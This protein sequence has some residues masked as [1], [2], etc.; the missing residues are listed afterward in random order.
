ME[1]KPCLQDTQVED[2][3]LFEK[4]NAAVSNETER[5]QKLSFR[6][7]QPTSRNPTR[8]VAQVTTPIENRTPTE[9]KTPEKP[10]KVNLLSEVKELKVELA[11]IRE[12]KEVNALWDTAPQVR[13]ASKCRKEVNLLNEPVGDIIELL[14][15]DDL[16]LQVANGTKIEYDGWIEVELQMAGENGP[17]EP[18][19][20]PILI[21]SQDNQKHLIIGFKVIEEVI[22]RSS[23]PNAHE[24]LSQMVNNSLPSLKE[25]EARMLVNLIQSLDREPDTAVLRVGKQD[26]HI[27]ARGPAE[28]NCQVHFVPLEEDLPDVF[29]VKEEGAWS[30]GLEVKG[31]LHH[32]KPGSSSHIY[33]SEKIVSADGYTM[34]PADVAAIAALKET[35]PQTI[36]TQRKL[37]GFISY[38]RNYIQD[39]SRLA[40]PLCELLSAKDGSSQFH[41]ARRPQEHSKFKSSPPKGQLSSNY[42][43]AWNEKHQERLNSLI[44]RLTQPVVMAYPNF[45]LPF[46]LH[47]DASGEGLGAVLYQEQGSTLR[48]VGYGSRTLTPAERNYHLH[49]GKLEFLALKWAITDKFRD[50]LFYAPSFVVFTDNNPLTYVMSS[51]KLNA[52]GHR[53]VAEL[54]DYNFTIKYRPGKSNVDAEILSRMPLDI[55]EYVRECTEEVPKDVL[56]ATMVAVRDQG[57]GTTPWVT[58]ISADMTTPEPTLKDLH[59]KPF[60]PREIK[61]AQQSDN[62]I[63][64][65]TYYKTNDIKPGRGQLQNGPQGAANLMR[66]WKKLEVD[67]Q[68]ILRRRTASRIQLVLPHAF[69][70]LALNELHN[71]MGHLGVER[72][73]ELARSRFYWPHM[74]RDIEYFV[75]QQCRC[76]KQKKPNTLTKAPMHHLTTSAPFEVISIDFQHLDKSKGGYEYVLLI[77]DNFTK[78]AQAY[79]TR[80]KTARMAAEKIYNEF[81]PRFGFP[82]RLHH[83]QGGE[84][85]NKLFHNLERFSGVSSS[86]TTPYHPQGNGQVECMNCTLLSMLR[87]LPEEKKANCKD[88][89]NKLIHAYNCTRHETAG[90]SPIYLMFGRSPRLPIDLLFGLHDSLHHGDY[91]EYVKT[92]QASMKQAYAIASRNTTKSSTRSKAYYDKKASAAVLRPGDRVL[93]RNLSERGGPGLLRSY[94]EEEI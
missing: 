71:E 56:E 86:R 15:E 53:W 72:V 3:E 81:I 9:D 24:V 32:I 1:I 8:L 31:C 88:S 44:D 6:H 47:T 73:A 34:D 69:V 13:V 18:L 41:K 63:R 19:T 27:A 91:P 58:A 40:K 94:W 29:E 54:A 61:E 60:S 74:Y 48:V 84:F 59:L 5:M 65:T 28:V 75:T 62:A 85:D 49:S 20:V 92:W 55:D 25:G 57:K 16:S 43:I 70:P 12:E 68:G 78:Y 14:G 77:V 30:G 67:E 50:Y 76:I 79:A 82:A 17:S 39:F 33:I 83:D 2:E 87:T 22:K 64:Y 46:V 80:N 52:T 51:A 93:V 38:C 89:L 66:E 45:E 35:K 10:P 37:L 21:G 23:D 90:F 42:K 26:I 4:L 36:G 11:T 7:N